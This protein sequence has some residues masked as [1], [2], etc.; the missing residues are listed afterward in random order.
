MIGG[1]A[2]DQRRRVFPLAVHEHVLVRHEHV[3]ED[4]QRFLAGELRIAGVDRAAVHDA[5]VVGLAA[6]D[7]GEARRIDAHRADHRPV[8]V[9]LGHAHG[10]H[11]DQPVR[12]DGAGLVHLG[13]G[14]VDAL[15]VALG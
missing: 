7:V 4:D 1:E 14:D 2:L 8:A 9:G 3:V 10:R 15:V 12:I 6:D 5:G 13:A 11:D